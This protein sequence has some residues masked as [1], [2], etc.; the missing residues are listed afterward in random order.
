MQIK[1]SRQALKVT[2]IYFFVAGGWILVSGKLLE[3]LVPNPD[4]RDE[5]EIF[6]GCVFVLA[7]GALLYFIVRRLLRGW[8]REAEQRRQAEE[9]LLR[10]QERYVLAQRAV[11]DGLWDW[12]IL[13][14][15]DYF[16]PRWKEIIGYRDD[17]FPNQRLAFLNQLHPDDLAAVKET[18]RRHLEQG[19]RYAIEFR[20]RHKDGSYRWLFSRGEGQRDA[21]GRAVRL[22]GATT[23]ITERKLIEEKLRETATQLLEAQRIANLG[24]YVLDVATGRWTCSPVMDELLGIADAGFTKDLAGWLEIVH[25]DDRAE[26]WHYWNEQVLKRKVVFDRIYR[27][28]RRNDRQERT[29]HGLGKLILD[30][31]G[32]VVKMLGVIQDITERKLIEEKLRKSEERYQSLFERSLDCVFLND[33]EGKFLDANQ[34]SLDLLGYQREDIATLTFA[35]LLTEDQLPLAFQTTEEIRTT[36]QQKQPAEFRLRG[37]DGREVPVE[38]QASLIYHDGKPFAIQGIARDLTQRKRAEEVLRESERFNHATLDAL[39]AH[40]AVLDEQGTILATNKAWR[41]FA[42]ANTTDWKAVSEGVNYLTACEMA[43]ASGDRDASEAIKGIREVASGARPAWFHEYPCHSPNAERWFYCRVTRFPGEGP[44]RVVV[45]HENITERKRAE[46]ALR[47]SEAKLA[48]IFNSSPVAMSLSTLKEGRFL[49]V[50]EAFVKIYGWSRDEVVGRTIF[51][52]DMWVNQEQRAALFATIQERGAAHNFELEMRVKSGQVIQIFWSGAPAIF[53]GERCLLASAMDITERKQAERQ[54][55]DARNYAQTLLAASPI[56]I[57]T[58][59]ADGQ[60]VSANEA[61]ARLVGTTVEN[62]KKQN[63][64]ELDSWKKSN[65]L[66][67]AELALATGQEQLF[68]DHILTG[69]G[70]ELWLSVRFVPFIHEG[71]SHLLMMSQDIS[72]RKRAEEQVHLQFSALTAAANAIV[73]TDRDGKIE[74]VNP[75]FTKLTGYSAEEAVGNNPRVL[76]SGEHPPAFYANLWATIS[77][78]NVWHGEMI[79]KRKDGRLYTEEMTIT[80]V[81]GADG[82]IAHFVA[83]KQDVTERHKLE[84]HLRQA[85]KMEAIGT[86]AG[87]IAHDFNNILGAMFGYGYLL[88]QDTTGNSVAQDSVGQ[89]LKA[90]N[91]AKELVQQILTFSRQ[92]EQKRQVIRLNTVVKEAMKFL[93]ASLPANIHIETDLAAD[94]PAVL[95]DPTQ[96]YQVVMNLATNAHQAM[97][98]RAG[99]ITVT[100]E[101]FQPDEQFIQAHSECR[102]VPYARLT[103]ADTGHGMNAKTLARIFEPFFTTKPV[104][105]GTGLGL[106]VVHGIVTSHEGII[107]VA[108]EVGQGTTFRIYFPA[109]TGQTALTDGATGKVVH[110]LRQKILLVD[111]E[112]ALTASLGKLLERLNYQVTTSNAARAAVELFRSTPA[113]FD[114]VITDL[115]MPEMNGLELARQLRAIRPDLPVIMVSGFSPELNQ[116]N[117]RAA[118]ICE[119]LEKP[120]VLPALTGALHRAVARA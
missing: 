61:A 36:G 6:K 92:R 71:K 81:R 59:R 86:L 60:T 103:I 35:S 45:A 10:S 120:I 27:I 106:A 80:P 72:E 68:E 24:S 76:K 108:S 4:V 52:L 102:P 62:L 14:D 11:N 90:A 100:L 51:E 93:R 109:Q 31:D 82:Q 34:A 3:L 63:F 5:I 96:I 78:G 16:S 66:K 49:D 15:E 75:A 118:G 79:N 95:A 25:P 65:L 91:R 87:G 7:T 101:P 37:K 41:E 29:V 117:L 43:V 53:G 18:T 97:E 30:E 64:R 40:V 94:T 70:I 55:V 1:A 74:W 56:G 110:G 17:E 113:Q 20:L 54:I 98:D 89:I 84:D 12:N 85:Q 105:K 38:I 39:G 116:E 112:P 8:A 57:I 50:N 46:Q 47:E 99:Q 22:I 69:Y 44:V 119:L 58:F 111:D 33:F 32:Q 23:D 77:T 19:E 114:L 13:N 104:G 88:Q 26:L 48:R 21:T 83:I 107:T 28:V 9:A 42:R 115:T 67:R 2:L 73:I